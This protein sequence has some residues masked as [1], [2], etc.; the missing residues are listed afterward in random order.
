LFYERSLFDS[1]FW[2]FYPNFWIEGGR[3][4]EE[5]ERRFLKFCISRGLRKGVEKQLKDI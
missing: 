2:I 3:G 4:K 5:K 1:D